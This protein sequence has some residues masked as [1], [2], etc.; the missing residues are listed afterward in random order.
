M[1]IAYH[2]A[3][4]AFGEVAA[5]AVAP[6]AEP[7]GFAA[8]PDALAA[9]RGGACARAVLPVSNSVAGPVAA[10]LALLPAPGLVTVGE[11]RVPITM[12]LL[13]VPGATLAGL[14]T[15]ASHPV[16]LAQ[17]S[18]AIARLGV[19][20]EAAATT[21]AAA[22]ALA[23]AP[24]PARGVFGSARAAQLCGLSVLLDDVGDDPGAV[25]TFVVLARVGDDTG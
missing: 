13:G 6:G 19:V 5:R 2:G 3:P 20:T 15:V 14:R 16:A 22:A 8:A 25:T 17:C 12:A 18:L 7:V 21:A 4:G 24:D 23:A 10:T 11:V 9:V 1:R